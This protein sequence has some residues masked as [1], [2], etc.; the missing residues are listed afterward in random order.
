MAAVSTLVDRIYRDFLNKPD[1]L[2]AFSRLDGA[3]NNSVTSLTYESGLF[4]SEEE[5]LLGNGALVEVDQEIMLVTAANTSTRTLT[6]ARGY[7]GTTAASH[8]DKANIFINP[9]F[10]RKSVFDAVADNIVRLYPT[11]YNVTTVTT[12][13]NSTYQEVAASTV[14]VLSSYV[15]NASGEQYTS[16]GIELLKNFPPSTT[17]TAVQFYN[18][19]NGKTVYLVDKRKFVRPSAETDDLSTAC[20]LEDEY[21]QIVMVGA[22]ADIV[23]ATDVDASTQEFITEKLAAENYPV[24]SG[25]RLRNALLRLRSL[26]I[27]EARGNLRSL[28]PAP[29]S[30]MNINYSA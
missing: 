3:I 26:L 10:P 17:N 24:G 13:S 30:I 19:S 20:L 25:E 14:E 22:V 5:N 29:V 11:L 2:S 4:S 27:D 18:T 12:T 15:Q 6:V 28:Y 8:D 1:D 21:Q 7:S 23:G 16:A 9:T